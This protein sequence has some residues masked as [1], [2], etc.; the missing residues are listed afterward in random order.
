MSANLITA[1]PAWLLAIVVIGTI[2]AIGALIWS[3]LPKRRSRDAD[4][5]RQIATLRNQADRA[6]SRRPRVRANGCAA[7]PGHIKAVPKA[8]KPKACGGGQCRHRADCSDTRAHL[9]H[10]A[11]ESHANNPVAESLRA[12]RIART[13]RAQA[14]KVDMAT[15]RAAV[16][17]PRPAAHVARDIGVSKT[18][19][20]SWRRRAAARVTTGVWGQLIA[21]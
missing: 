16:A 12:E 9:A 4:I 6:V 15:M 10:I 5:D 19:V 14:G 8:E 18:S 1:A 2:G 20:A 21:R 11:R 7:T 3:A 17:S 13:R